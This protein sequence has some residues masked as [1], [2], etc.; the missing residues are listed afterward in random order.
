MLNPETTVGGHVIAGDEFRRLAEEQEVGKKGFVRVGSAEFKVYDEPARLPVLRQ[1]YSTSLESKLFDEWQNEDWTIDTASVELAQRYGLDPLSVRY[2]LGIQERQIKRKQRKVSLVRRELGNSPI[3]AEVKTLVM[4][5]SLARAA[6]LMEADLSVREAAQA[7]A[8]VC[9]KILSGKQ[10]MATDAII[11]K[12]CS[13][14]LRACTSWI[15]ASDDFMQKTAD[16]L[17]SVGTLSETTTSVT[18][19]SNGEGSRIEELGR[20]IE[21]ED[22][23]I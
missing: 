1:A 15:K 20:E 16:S 19:K 6:S 3:A 5:G 12:G 2:V 18:E 21:A 7:A 8:E 17:Q 9:R 23:A 4:E 22:D 11:L 13:D 14:V 10:P